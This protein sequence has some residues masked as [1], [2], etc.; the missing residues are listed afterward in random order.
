M[1]TIGVSEAANGLKHRVFRCR[2]CGHTES[3]AAASDPLY[4]SA[5]WLSGEVGCRPVTY[6]IKQGRLVPKT[7]IK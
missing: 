4:N 2:A 3:N 5:G 7:G 6:E 1:S